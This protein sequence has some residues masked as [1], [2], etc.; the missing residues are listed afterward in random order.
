[1][2]INATN[3][4]KI[5]DL[6]NYVKQVMEKVCV[7]LKEPNL[8]WVAINHFNTDQ[9]HTH[10]LIRGKRANGKNLVI[11]R[12]YVS[13]GIRGRA[14]EQAH[15]ILGNISRCDAARGMFTRGT[16][17]RWTDIDIRLKPRACGNGGT[18]VKA[19]L[20]R[21]DTVGA[22]IR[23]PRVASKKAPGRQPRPKIVSHPLMA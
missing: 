12:T 15:V 13:H 18:L 3:A 17:N 9:P 7:D 5:E 1:V 22:L 16:A 4:D 6:D 23:P 8:N 19:E 10:I 20:A 21:H 11:P 14:Q 2:I